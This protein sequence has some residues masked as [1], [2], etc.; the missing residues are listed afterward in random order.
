M[1]DKEI[2]L[3]FII[4]SEIKGAILNDLEKNAIKIS[5]SRLVDTYYIP[6]FKEFE[7]NGETIECVR[8][9]ENDKGCFLTYKKIHKEANPIYCDEYE[10]MVSDKAQMQKILIALGFSIQMIIDKTRETYKMD[11]FEFDFDLVKNLGDLLEI[12]LKD[13]NAN[14]EMI[15]DFVGKYGLGKSDVT[16]DGIQTLMKKARGENIGDNTNK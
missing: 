16:H 13:D 11:K 8:I 7:I 5:K 6:Y 3:K 15:Y 9:R 1:K 12:E 10:T 14:I 4:N 2:E